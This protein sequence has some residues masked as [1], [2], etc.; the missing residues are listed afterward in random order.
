MSRATELSIE[1][2][3]CSK[4]QTLAV[5]A[6]GKVHFWGMKPLPLDGGEQQ[7]SGP[8]HLTTFSSQR[9]AEITNGRDFFSIVLTGSD[10]ERSFA[11]G[12]LLNGTV[13]AGALA[14]A[15]VRAVDRDGRFLTNGSDRIVVIIGD[16]A[17]GVAYS[18]Q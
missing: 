3:C 12:A 4:A 7:A 8:T 17:S 1:G 5:G 18:S 15:T 14:K 13:A 6:Q 9:V 2:V 16:L 11:T 10:P